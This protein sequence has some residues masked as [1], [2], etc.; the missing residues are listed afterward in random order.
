[1]RNL[2]SSSL[3]EVVAVTLGTSAGS[4]ILMALLVLL[5]ALCLDWLLVQALQRSHPWVTRRLAPQYQQWG[6]LGF[7]VLKLGLRVLIWSLA[8]G[9]SVS[10]LPSLQPFIPWLSNGGNWVVELLVELFTTPLFTIGSNK[11]SLSSILLFTVIALLVFI[12]A[13]YLSQW[14]KQ[15]IL[16]RLGLDRGTQEAVATVIGYLLTALGFMVVL[17]TAGIDLSSLAVLAGVLGIGL[18]FGLQNLASNFISGLALLFEQ[19][20]KVGDFIEVDGLLGTVEKISIRSTVVRTQDSVFVIVPN[21]RF[22]EKNVVNWS[23][24]DPESRIHVPV[25]VAYGSDTVAVT[26]ALLAAARK[27]PRVLIYPSPKVWFKSFGD[28]ALEFELLIWIN[29][30]QE[31]EPIKSALNFLIEQ[32]F[33]Q[34]GIKVPFPQRELTFHNL[35]GLKDLWRD[36]RWDSDSHGPELLDSSD[37][38]LPGARM[39]PVRS[40]TLQVLL[41]KMD[42]FEQCSNAELCILIE[43][44][45]Q[46]LYQ[47]QSLICRE[48]EPGNSFYILLSG[49]VEVVSEQLAQPIAILKE[50]DFF[51]EIALFTGM[52]RSATVRALEE[53]DVFVVDHD[54]LQKLLSNH[55]ELAER[56]AQELSQRQQ[57][58][59]EL[60]LLITGDHTAG[61]RPLVWIRQRL[62]TLF[63]I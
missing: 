6:E 49:T 57:V 19:P 5:A 24:R 60:G 58:L 30:P 47:P 51:G 56:I 40:R 32:E 38:S 18:G 61:E 29:Q 20:I 52:P 26:E 55:P 27:E 45:Y 39:Q 37:A 15:R 31:F 50:G 43:Q 42:Y 44:G 33:R 12:A 23:Y 54:A 14:I 8:L 62:R 59:Q 22:I 9:W 1:M 35:D 53:V 7:S 63:G 4:A 25:G 17:Q 34:R 36:R 2:F 28:S 46:K 21:I 13:R 3:L 11:L 16:R 41:R 48:H 10:L